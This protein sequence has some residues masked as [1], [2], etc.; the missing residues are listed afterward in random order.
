[1]SPR[2]A[3]AVRRPTVVYLG[4][5]S[6]LGDRL[7]LMRRGLYCLATHPEIEVRAVSAVYET[8]YVGP[9]E[10]PPYLNAC[11]A[12]ATTLAPRVLL[13]VLKLLEQRLGRAP[14]TH[15]AP[16]PLDLDILLYGDLRRED[17]V[18]TLPHP[19]LADRA[20]VMAPL[21]ELAPDLELPDSGETVSSVYAKIRDRGGPWLRLFAGSDLLP[22]PCSGRKDDWRAA[23]ALHGG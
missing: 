9:G 22:R 6:N 4:L 5:G 3:A 2:P 20:F 17:P 23:L 21:C 13:V 15:M 10:Q 19:R 7:A 8:E 1:M 11:V 16:R 12:V 18:L 14:D